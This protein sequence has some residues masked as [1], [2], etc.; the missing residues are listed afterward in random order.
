MPT[1]EDLSANSIGELLDWPGG[2]QAGACV[3]WEHYE[4]RDNPVDQRAAMK[5]DWF[6]QVTAEF[7]CCGKLARVDSAV[8]GFVQF[9]LSRYLP[10]ALGY[11][12]G[13]PS[14]DAVFASCLHV[15]E[16]WRGRGVGRALLG[17]ALESAREHGL[18]AVETYARQGPEAYDNPSGL[19]EFWIKNGFRIVR[20]EG[21][22][23]LVRKELRSQ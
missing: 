8:V 3:Y 10:C 1:L 22:F 2:C 18:A 19:L 16:V 6:R 17:A 14:E 13:P 12:C 20:E 7:G 15:A 23:A 4:H 9:A 21:E 5:E 11:G